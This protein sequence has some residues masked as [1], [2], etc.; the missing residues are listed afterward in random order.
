[1]QPTSCSD[2][3]KTST[4]LASDGRSMCE[5]DNKRWGNPCSLQV[6]PGD[7]QHE[8]TLRYDG[9]EREWKSEDIHQAMGTDALDFLVLYLRWCGWWPCWVSN[10]SIGCHKNTL[11]DLRIKT[12][13][14]EAQRSFREGVKWR[15]NS[16]RILKKSPMPSRWFTAV[17]WDRKTWDGR[18]WKRVWLRITQG[19]LPRFPDNHTTNTS[20][21]RHFGIRTRRRTPHVYK[22]TI[23]RTLL[24][25]IW[26]DEEFPGGKFE[27]RVRN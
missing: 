26:I 18:R 20:N 17:V 12:L 25:H 5:I 6:V 9:G 2:Q 16:R 22:R 15:A 19:P 10:Q 24:G 4:V 27:D 23:H 7:G 13:M 14:Q 21:R 1:M 11:A 8:H 3:V